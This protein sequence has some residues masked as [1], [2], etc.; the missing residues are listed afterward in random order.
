MATKN[1]R[2]ASG[3]WWAVGVMVSPVNGMGKWCGFAR[4]AR[5]GGAWPCQQNVGPE[6]NERCASRVCKSCARK[7]VKGRKK[8][9]KLTGLA[10]LG[11]QL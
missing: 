8:T 2:V 9:C 6:Q 7:P 4:L 5:V 11:V 3:V 10:G 1:W